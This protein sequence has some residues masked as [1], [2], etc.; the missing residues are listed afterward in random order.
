MTAFGVKEFFTP[1]RPVCSPKGAV[2]ANIAHI[3]LA[4]TEVMK[5]SGSTPDFAPTGNLELKA[6]MGSNHRV[7]LP[8]DLD[9]PLLEAIPPYAEQIAALRRQIG[10]VVPRQNLK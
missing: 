8:K 5:L 10:A 2:V 6:W 3:P 4:L 9:L 1:E 7:K